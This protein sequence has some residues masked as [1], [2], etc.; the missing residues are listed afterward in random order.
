MGRLRGG[1]PEQQRLLKSSRRV[2]EAVG[3]IREVRKQPPS[4]VT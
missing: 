4:S 1:R 2:L 3:D